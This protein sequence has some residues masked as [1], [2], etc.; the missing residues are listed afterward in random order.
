MNQI[1][2]ELIT[3][4]RN[5]IDIVDVI[6][7]YVK[8]NPRGKNFFGLCPFHD[9][10]N[11]SMSVAKD[12]QI[13]T[14]FSC[15]ATGNV[16]KFIEDIENVSFVEAVKKCAD[17]VNI[18]LDIKINNSKINEKFKNLYDI[19]EDTT[20]LYHQ[21]LISENGKE[22]RNYLKQRGFDDEIINTFRIGLSLKDRTIITRSMSSKYSKLDILKTG[23]VK[24]GDKG[25]Y[26]S[27]CNRIMFPLDDINGNIVGFSGRIYNEEDNSKY[28]NT[29]ET[30]IFKKTETLYNYKRA[31]NIARRNGYVIVMEGFMDVIRAHKIGYDN[32]VATMGTA[33]TEFHANL[34]KKM[35]KEVYL[36]FDGDNAGAKATYSCME[37]LKQVGV[38]PKIIRLEDNMDPDDYIKKFGKEGFEEKLNNPMSV[39]EF[40]VLHLKKDYNL[41]N[42]D[43]IALYSRKC[44]NLLNEVNDNI[45]REMMISKM[46]E[47]TNIKEEIIRRELTPLAKQEEKVIEEKV[48][49]I[50]KEPQPVQKGL[51][52]Y[53]K[54]EINLIYYM[55]N[56]K[57]VIFIYDRKISFMPTNEMRKLARE[58]SGFYHKHNYI[59]VADF[60][61]YAS[62]NYELTRTL[63][64]VLSQNLREELDIDEIMD[65]IAVIKEYNINEQIRKIKNEIKET[66]EVEKQIALIDKIYALIKDRDE[67][68]L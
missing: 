17:M 29:N 14:C 4:I 35:A 40:Q 31:V 42:M 49:P 57:Q 43:E 38:I 28:I 45:L 64:R 25:L 65:Y 16:F 37:K 13:Y 24:E 47:G 30:D 6:E 15:G 52:K 9:D 5:S 3:E 36:C 54:A 63:N 23:L 20:K 55:L 1:P 8:L 18:K 61:T 51:N 26:D 59:N 7:G 48:K 66:N 19:Y 44:V 11:A 27:Y 53:Q 67:L 68:Y 12:K 33:I 50:V 56:Y 22:A 58:I 32:C 46:C 39:S 62:R 41:K 2:Q 34:L 10:N 60:M 21:I